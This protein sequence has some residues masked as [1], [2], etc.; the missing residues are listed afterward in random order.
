[1]EEVERL[2]KTDGRGAGSLKG[3]VEIPEDTDSEGEEDGRVKATGAADWGKKA[4]RRQRRVLRSL[5]EADEKRRKEEEEEAGSD[6]EIEELLE[7]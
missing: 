4:R 6:K 5:I 2:R 1:M 3:Q 7:G